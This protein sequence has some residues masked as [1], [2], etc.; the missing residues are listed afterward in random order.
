MPVNCTKA[1]GDRNPAL[2][3]ITEACLRQG[4]LAQLVYAEGNTFLDLHT[5]KFICVLLALS[6]LLAEKN[7]SLS[8][9]FFPP[10]WLLP[11]PVRMGLLFSYSS[12]GKP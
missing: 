4:R 12:Y 2:A 3:L 6:V 9:F 10:S 1:S 5:S 11:W 7:S 8:L